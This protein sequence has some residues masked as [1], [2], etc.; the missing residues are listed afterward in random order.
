VWQVIKCPV[1]L[2]SLVLI[3]RG[4]FDDVARLRGVKY[5]NLIVPFD[6]G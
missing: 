5:R 6:T 3:G 2:D 4:V 1:R